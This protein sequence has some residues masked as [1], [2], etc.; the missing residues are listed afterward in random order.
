MISLALCYMCACV[1]TRIAWVCTC[2]VNM[3]AQACVNVDAE[4]WVGH[5]VSLKQGLWLSI[6]LAAWA[7]LA[8]QWPPRGHLSLPPNVVNAWLCPA[9]LSVLGIWTHAYVA[10]TLTHWTTFPACCQILIHMFIFAWTHQEPLVVTLYS[11]GPFPS[12]SSDNQLLSC[13][14]SCNAENCLPTCAFAQAS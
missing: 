3:C 8:G 12:S 5:R 7:T 10:S 13:G 2:N 6:T 14:Q 9:F 4:A 1:R 11:W